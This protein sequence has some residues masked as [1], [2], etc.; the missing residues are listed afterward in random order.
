[1]AY[2]KDHPTATADQLMQY[3]E[4]DDT[5][6]PEIYAVFIGLTKK[7]HNVIFSPDESSKRICALLQHL[8]IP[9]Y[10]KNSREIY[11]H[12]TKEMF[13]YLYEKDTQGY[14]SIDEFLEKTQVNAFFQCYYRT[15]M[16]M[17]LITKEKAYLV[18]DEE[19]YLS[20]QIETADSIQVLHLEHGTEKLFV[21]HAP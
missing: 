15:D 13:E 10:H 16:S 9:Y 7:Q 20:N 5:A 1:M 12:G 18:L 2:L 6:P 14:A 4:I 11:I 21:F 17:F 3:A 19:A 8:G